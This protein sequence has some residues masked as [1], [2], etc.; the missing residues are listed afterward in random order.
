MIKLY[1]DFITERLSLA[2]WQVEQ[3][4]ELFED[5]ATIPFISRYRKERTGGL[6]EMQVAEI[7]H[8]YLNFIELDRRKA[9]ILKSIEEQGVLTDELRKTIEDQVDSQLLEDIYL[10]YRPKRR[11][12][13][14]IAKERGLEPLAQALYTMKVNSVQSAAKPFVKGDVESLD[15]A[16]AGASDIVAEWISEDAT[17]RGELRN[18]YAKWGTITSHIAKGAKEKE[19]VEKYANYFNFRQRIDQIQSYRVLALLRGADEGFLSVKVDVKE[20]FALERIERKIYQGKGRPS[21]ENR[22]FI[23]AAIVDSYRRLLHSSIENESINT[24]KERADIDSIRVFGENLR[25]LLL[26]PPVGQKRTLAIDPGF[27]TGCKVVCLDEQGNLLYNETIFPH[28]PVN[29]RST[30]M[31]KLSNMIEA[32]KIEVIAIGNGTAGRETE[33]FIQKMMLPEDIKVFSVNEDGASIYSASQLARDEFPDYDVTVRGAVSIGRRLMDPL[34]ELVKI[35]PKSIGV[36][37]YQH[38]VNQKLLKEKLDTVVESCVNSVG[39]NLN[40]ASRHLLAYVSGIGP[41]LAN[42][43]VEYRSKNGAFLS[44][45]QL[46]DVKKLG[47]KSYEQ[48]AGFLR[49]PGADNPLDNSAVHP[50]RYRLVERMAKDIGVSVDE[51]IADSSLRDRISLDK[52][53]DEQVGMPTLTDI[54]NEL[55]K[56]GRDPRGAVKECS[57]SEEILTI[58]DVKIGMDLPGIVTNITAFGAFVD[59]GIKQNGLIHISHMGRGKRVNDPS[60]VLKIQQQVN[61]R[62]IS[63]DLQRGRIGL[64]LL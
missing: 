64:E 36:G 35:D 34:A 30:S 11:T 27:R 38:D 16:I 33:A 57:F 54:M 23:D 42:N 55:A 61:T 17:I 62:V 56:P 51:L 60:D 43:I 48:C 32:Y 52:Y 26:S 25:Q 4:I 24:I 12:R 45:E 40:T 58:D 15:D 46:K 50:E 63:V 10:P 47:P 49:I 37:Q 20:D 13:A 29:E 59:I 53:V 41:S 19:G 31:R 5:G 7:K 22:A 14:S 1:L 44:R 8:Y 18:L 21:S 9:A 2:T 28:P 39:V 3:C 6:D